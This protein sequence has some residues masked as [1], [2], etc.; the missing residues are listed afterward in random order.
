MPHDP[1]V[2]APIKLGML[3]RDK[4][5]GLKGT[6]YSFFE[7]EYMRQVSIQPMGD[8]E[9]VIDLLSFDTHSL[10]IIDPVHLTGATVTYPLDLANKF[11]FGDEVYDR[12]TGF[13][14]KI[15][16]RTIFINGC[17]N[18]SIRPRIDKDGKI[19]DA[20]GFP[21]G[22][23]IRVEPVATTPNTPKTGG[24]ILKAQRSV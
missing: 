11:E 21:A 17:V 5:T 19:P 13:R 20:H 7:T 3:I 6:A 22:D 23:I 2:Y 10:E 16:T 14:G 15:Y 1:T 24:P 18:Y 8:G 4:V 9:K 12:Q